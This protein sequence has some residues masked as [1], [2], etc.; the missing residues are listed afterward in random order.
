MNRRV[1]VLTI[2]STIL[3]PLT[4]IVSLLGGNVSTVDGNI[5]GMRHPAW[6]IGL[7]IGLVLLAWGI[8]QIFRRRWP[9]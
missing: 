3:L 1:Y 9:M 4:L 6:F 5:L 2:V 8:Y 7:C